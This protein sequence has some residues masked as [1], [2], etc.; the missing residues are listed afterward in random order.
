MCTY[1][2]LCSQSNLYI[3]LIQC[4]FSLNVFQCTAFIHQCL[5]LSC[6]SRSAFANC[7]Q[8][9]CLGDLTHTSWDVQ[10]PDAPHSASLQSSALESSSYSG[11]SC[12]DKPEPAPSLV[13]SLE[14]LPL[15]FI[16]NFAGDGNLNLCL[17]I[18][19]FTCHKTPLLLEYIISSVEWI[20]SSFLNR[21]LLR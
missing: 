17:I 11:C 2:C 3:G 14:T 10:L 8:V 20:E 1:V 18:F 12:P 16:R 5:K 9:S 15:R 6:Y 4:D 7:L 13:S 19:L 21:S